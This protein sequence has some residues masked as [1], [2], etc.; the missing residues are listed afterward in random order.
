MDQ[1]LIFNQSMREVCDL[2]G[3]TNAELRQ[4]NGRLGTPGGP[5]TDAIGFDLRAQ[6]TNLEVQKIR[7][8]TMYIRVQLGVLLLMVLCYVVHRW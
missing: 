8:N 1:M 2:I 3:E 6:M 7:V 4:T 5:L